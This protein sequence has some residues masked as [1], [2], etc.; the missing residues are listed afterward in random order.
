MA[1]NTK[2]I[3]M[4]PAQIDALYKKYHPLALKETIPAHALW[5]IKMPEGTITAYYSG[6]VLFQGKEIQTLLPGWYV[7][8]TEDAPEKSDAPAVQKTAGKSIF[9]QAGSDEVGTGD[10]FGPMVV[11]N[12]IVKDEQTAGALQN[13]GVTDSKTLTDEKIRAIAPKVKELVTYTVMALPVKTFNR[14]F[15]QNGINMNTIKSKMHNQGYVNLQKQ[16]GPLPALTVIDQFCPEKKYYEHLE[17][18]VPGSSKDHIIVKDIHFETKAES[19]YPAV[20]AASVL[21]RA[22]FLEQMD[23]MSKKYDFEFPK[24]AGAGVDAKGREFVTKHGKEALQ[25]T[26]KLNFSNTARILKSR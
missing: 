10:Y 8:K 4:S 20:A 25:E 22:E 13:L 18:P 21:A 1:Q 24:G 17:I 5:S 11:A 19:K 2:S 16:A 26:A 23:A 7:R 9:P 3:Q 6:K 15:G 12:V 14:I